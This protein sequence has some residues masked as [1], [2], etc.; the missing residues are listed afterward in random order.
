M[1]AGRGVCACRWP[2][3]ADDERPHGFTGDLRQVQVLRSAAETARCWMCCL[4]LCMR[5]GVELICMSIQAIVW[6]QL[7]GVCG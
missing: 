4:T 1:F 6:K 5:Y 3:V 7:M 2:C